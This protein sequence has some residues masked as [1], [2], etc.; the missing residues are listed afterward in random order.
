MWAMIMKEFRQVRRDR[1]TLAMMIVLPV[2][3]LVVLGYAASFDVKSITV[4]AAG[5]QAAV[6]ACCGRRAAGGAGRSRRSTSRRSARARAGPGRRT[7]FVTARPRWPSSP[8]GAR[9]M[10]LVDGSQL[11]SAGPRWP[12]W[13]ARA[14]GSGGT[15]GPGC[16]GG[17]AATGTCRPR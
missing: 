2:L 3:L 6:P 7:S 15:Q 8:A 1:R 5:P 14:Q 16:P 12:R 4:V 13:P 11:F 9:P 10:V 17:R